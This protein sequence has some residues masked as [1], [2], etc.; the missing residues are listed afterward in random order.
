VLEKQ[1]IYQ[2]SNE[3]F[4]IGLKKLGELL[5][6]SFP[7]P[8]PVSGYIVTPDIRMIRCYQR[9]MEEPVFF[10]ISTYFMVQHRAI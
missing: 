4:G 2:F 7:H 5:A 9:K 1:N 10:K 8:K 6:I 3:S